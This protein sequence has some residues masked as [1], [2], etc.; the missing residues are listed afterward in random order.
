[1]TK[2][3]FK[4][5]IQVAQEVAMYRA[6]YASDGGWWEKLNNLHSFVFNGARANDD[7]FELEGECNW[8]Q[9]WQWEQ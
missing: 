8:R 2:R 7:M 6:L 1:M 9:A 4:M 3:P 5:G